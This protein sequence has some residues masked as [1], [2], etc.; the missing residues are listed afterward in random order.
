VSS[1]FP[2]HSEKRMSDEGQTP[3]KKRKRSK[4]PNKPK[5]PLT[6]FLMW[7]TDRRKEVPTKLTVQQLGEEWKALPASLKKV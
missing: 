6:G 5:R 1:C 3:K 2:L 4:D 7:S